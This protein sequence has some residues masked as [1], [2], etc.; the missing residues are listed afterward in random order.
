MVAFLLSSPP[1]FS[2][3]S[4]LCHYL[5]VRIGS[6]C[7]VILGGKSACALV[8]F[9]NGIYVSGR[10]RVDYTIGRMDIFDSLQNK[11]E[12]IRKEK[13]DKRK[14]KKTK[15][16]AKGRVVPL[17]RGALSS[18]ETAAR[19]LISLPRLDY[20]DPQTH[21]ERGISMKA[22]GAVLLRRLGECGVDG[23]WRRRER[24]PCGKFFDQRLGWIEYQLDGEVWTVWEYQAISIISTIIRFVWDKNKGEVGSSTFNSP[25][26]LAF[27][28]FWNIFLHFNLLLNSP[29]YDTSAPP[30][31][32]IAAE[33]WK[34]DQEEEGW[35]DTWDRILARG[36]SILTSYVASVT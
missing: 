14:I 27:T 11:S 3:L 31:Q 19:E 12:D 1:P 36:C 34:V 24:S 22:T 4:F 18:R 30:I 26:T 32:S 5:V 33:G 21:V 23:G 20:D 9:E 29:H 35:K 15:S 8:P 10:A 13:G 7:K 16:K 25:P 28:F 6:W 2:F 17:R